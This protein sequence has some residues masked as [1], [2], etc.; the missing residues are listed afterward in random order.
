MHRLVCLGLSHRTAPVELRER[1]GAL[2][3]GAER[4][5]A[6]TEHAALQT[7]YRVELYA[8]LTSGVEAA[9]EELAAIASGQHDADERA[10]HPRN[11]TRTRQ[12]EGQHAT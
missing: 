6:V 10:V 3:A 9:R 11:A 7:C 4:C 5:P 8:R 1:L 12:T 2:G